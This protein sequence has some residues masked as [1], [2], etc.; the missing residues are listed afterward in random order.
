MTLTLT[1]SLE[2]LDRM[3]DSSATSW[4][5]TATG[6]STH[7][8]RC[9]QCKAYKRAIDKA[10]YERTKEARKAK[11]RDYYA[12]NREAVRAKQ[13][14]YREANAEEIA[15]KAKAA[16]QA[17]PEQMKARAKAW[18]AANP[19][20]AKELAAAY[21]ERNR[22]LIR[23]KSLS[24]YYELMK[25]DPNKVRAWRLSSAQTPNGIVSS[26]SARHAR[27]GARMTP[28]AKAWWLGL[29]DPLCTY[30]GEPATTIDH[31]IPLS[32]GGNGEREN[33]TPSCKRCNSRKSQMPVEDFLRL[34]R[35]EG[36]L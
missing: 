31:I 8:C 19:Q 20:R 24:R 35:Q 6:Y 5:G 3:T 13:T 27:R 10:N 23:A 33:L 29:V 1:T 7:K 30:C 17:N 12:E 26:R 2:R 25:N 22:E 36:G 15:A 18:K 14:E 4:H 11:A 28:E 9:D 32:K 16:Y 21:R 34:L